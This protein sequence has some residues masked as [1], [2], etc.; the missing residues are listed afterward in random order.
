[1]KLRCMICNKEFE[2]GRLQIHL[3]KIHKE[4]LIDYYLKYINVQENTNCPICGKP[5]KFSGFKNGFNKTCG[6]RSCASKLT[7]I[8]FKEKQ[9]EGCRKRNKQWREEVI[10]GKTKQQSII[11]SGKDKRKEKQKETSQKISIKL[12]EQDS[13]GMTSLQRTCLDKYG[14]TN[15]MKS[16]TIVNKLKETFLEQYGVEWITQSEPIKEKI[17]SAMLKKYGV[18]NYVKTEEYKQKQKQRYKQ[19]M[20]QRILKYLSEN[21]LVL[22]CD[23]SEVYSDEKSILQIKCQKCNNKYSKVWNDIQSWWACPVCKPTGS[24]YE[25]E[26]SQLLTSWNIQFLRNHRITTLDGTKFELDFYISNKLIAI[27]FDGLYWHCNQHQLNDQYHLNKTEKCEELG[28][29]LIHIFEDEWILKKDI[30][31]SRLKHI[32]N[33]KDDLVIYARNCIIQEVSSSAKKLFLEKNHIQGNDTSKINLGLFFN[34]KLISLMTFSKGNISKGSKSEY[35]IYELS[36]FCNSIGIHVPGS[37]SKLLSSF[38]KMVQWKE[39][40]SYADRRWSQGQ[41]YNKLGFSFETKTPVNY[42][43]IDL[44]KDI[45][46]HH[47]FQFRKSNLKTMS[48]Y[49]KDLTEKQIMNLEGWFWIYDCG[50]LKFVMENKEV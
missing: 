10:N 33:L 47:R 9:K 49:S 17:K 5:K 40:Y 15:P 6:N 20:L 13:D 44:R 11:E 21:D 41:V 2:I 22:E 3:I 16:Q 36:R 24:S 32:L 37:A 4:N 19:M 18:D 23:I 42:W 27:E 35:G 14:V 7:N 30:V 12:K 28:I 1:M 48:N 29:K 50:S 26:I 38:K 43:Y 46:R 25:I 8:L 31:I 34:D 45:L 39:I